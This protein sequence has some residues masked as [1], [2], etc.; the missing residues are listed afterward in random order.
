MWL[1]PDGLAWTNRDPNSY[2]LPTLGGWFWGA[3]CANGTYVIVG[4]DQWILTTTD[5]SH[6]INRS[7]FLNNTLHSVAFG[8]GR[9]VAVD[10]SGRI[11][12]S[13]NASDWRVLTHV[14]NGLPLYRVRYVAGRFVTVGQDG[15]VA[16]SIDG[17]SWQAQTLPTTNA[18]R[19]IGYGFG[20]HVLTGDGGR[21]FVSPNGTNWVVQNS[22]TTNAL[23]GVA[24]G[25]GLLV[26]VGGSV[27]S[28]VVATSTNGLDWSIPSQSG[29]AELRSV[30]YGHE[31]FVAV[32]ALYDFLI[33]TNGIAWTTYRAGPTQ[34][35]RDIAFADGYFVAVGGAGSYIMA[36]SP[37]GVNWPLNTPG[38]GSLRG[39]THGNGTF[40]AVGDWG[41]V[42]QS[43]PRVWLSMVPG[44]A[45]TLVVSG[46][47]GDYRIDRLEVSGETFSWLPDTN[48][49]ATT[50][51][52]AWPIADES[53]WGVYRGVWTP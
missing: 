27:N 33:S 46:P 13:T 51:P 3:T 44:P 24:L 49:T 25:G 9:F 38:G 43:D 47:L 7:S 40:V 17:S 52:W 8:Q 1:S 5:A 45:P 6:F 42:V 31:R 39:L 10:G 26:A 2:G 41:A 48:T 32:S 19:G 53:R 29:G 18:L 15:L 37:D 22:G 20:L 4:Q 36:T 11:G 14:S 16:S 30:A 34:R 21:I 23:N 12:I 28:R 50:S 35:W